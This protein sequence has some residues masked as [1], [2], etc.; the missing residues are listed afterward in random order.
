[1]DTSNWTV[2]DVC[3]YLNQ[4][5]LSMYSQAFH[6]NDIS[7]KILPFLTH[8]MMKELGITSLGH[9]IILSQFIESIQKAEIEFPKFY[10]EWDQSIS[11]LVDN[12]YE[13]M[14]DS[15]V[16]LVERVTCQLC[17]R[18]YPRSFIDRHQCICRKNHRLS[19]KPASSKKST[20]IKEKAMLPQSKLDQFKKLHG[21]INA[22]IAKLEEQSIETKECKHCGKKLYQS[23]L[24]QHEEACKKR[25]AMVD[26]LAK[27]GNVPKSDFKKQHEELQEIIKMSKSYTPDE[28]KPMENQPKQTKCHYC[29]KSLYKSLL[30]QHEEACRKRKAMIDNLA[31]EGNVPKTDF[32]KSHTQLMELLKTSK[33]QSQPQQAKCQ[34]CGKCLYSSLLKQHEDACKK[35][36][37]AIDNLAREGNAPKVDFNKKHQELIKEIKAMKN[38]QIDTSKQPG[39]T[40]CR[41]CGK[42]CYNSLLKQH[43]DACQKRMTMVNKLAKEGNVPKTDFRKAHTQLMDIFKTFKEAETNKSNEAQPEQV[44]CKHCGKSLY[45][46]LLKQHEDACGKRK[47]YLNNISKVSPSKKADYK[48]KHT[49]LLDFISKAKMAASGQKFEP[50]I[51]M[52]QEETETV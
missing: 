39:Q 11:P 35:R 46:S 50:V 20:P 30:N 29:G 19:K 18:Q 43:E 36:K 12:E 10:K 49:E 27:E 9:R 1:M 21:T 32:R 41:F 7:G 17:N 8:D 16:P 3:N 31:K 34:Y 38:P 47:T 24:S 44:K 52:Q 14:L 37:S 42:E 25:K 48:Q 26:S 5:G 51:Q 2:T 22:M 28:S 45:K 13:S 33:S 6:D 4:L 40:K 23:L 15:D